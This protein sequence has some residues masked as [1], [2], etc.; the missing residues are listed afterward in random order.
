MI[1][2]L[3]NFAASPVAPKS[4]I[5]PQELVGTV[6]F[7][8]ALGSFEAGTA[9]AIAPSIEQ[10]AGPL[11]SGTSG[12]ELAG[13]VNASAPAALVLPLA[14]GNALPEGL[15]QGGMGLPPGL[16]GDGHGEGQERSL[17]PA[18]NGLILRA[19]QAVTGQAGRSNSP[20]EALVKTPLAPLRQG[21]DTAPNAVSVQS[22]VLTPTPVN[23]QTPTATLRQAS[24]ARPPSPPG[25]P[26]QSNGSTLTPTDMKAPSDEPVATVRAHDRVPAKADGAEPAD[27]VTPTAGP[28]SN[29]LTIGKGEEVAIARSR[30][31]VEMMARAAPQTTP[32]PLEPAPSQ[33]VPVPSASVLSASPN[34]ARPKS[35]GTDAPLEQSRVAS[36]NVRAGTEAGTQSQPATLEA[37][38]AKE[39]AR[40]VQPAPAAEPPLASQS[41]VTAAMAAS[42]RPQLVGAVLPPHTATGVAG[43]PVDLTLEK[44]LSP[45]PERASV[46]QNGSLPLPFVAVEEGAGLDDAPTSQSRSSS[47]SVPTSPLAAQNTQPASADL[48]QSQ[49]ANASALVSQPSSQPSAPVAAPDAGNAGRL[50]AQLESTIE[51]L[52]ETRS[53]AAASKPELTVRHQE[54]GA[55]T[56][57]LEALGNDLRAT[58]SARDP[59]FVPAIQNALAERAVA[60]SSETSSSAGQRGSDQSGAQSNSHNHNSTGSHGHGWQS[61]PRYGSSTGSGQGTSQ[62]YRGQTE[63]RDDELRSNPG[64]QRAS[65]GKQASDGERFA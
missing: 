52:T 62:P 59:G 39:L 60:A 25:L 19:G 24:E 54:F 26:L 5:A 31:P 16:H 30:P 36:A 56:M 3:S 65:G 8:L 47:Q 22:P 34:P 41:P 57:R 29:G 33:S 2:T 18:R 61:D 49:P 63:N 6:N 51:Q 13:D 43:K 55:I 11:A 40:P 10:N 48:V 44:A 50:A 53:N 45:S 23:P 17:E 12:D 46:I 27:L 4:A 37:T 9:Q 21:F 28:R 15:Q 7:G 20:G 42:A 32:E 64:E 35:S 14:H 38:R 1:P 58:L